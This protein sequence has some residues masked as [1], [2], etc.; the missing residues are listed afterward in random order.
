MVQDNLQH[1]HPMD[2]FVIQY[3]YS[4]MVLYYHNTSLLAISSKQSSLN[5]KK[6]H[7]DCLNFPDKETSGQ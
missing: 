6:R 4:C 7:L 5:K 2:N 1:Y 3:Y